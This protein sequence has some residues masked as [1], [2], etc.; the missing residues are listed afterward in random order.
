MKL[1]AML[2]RQAASFGMCSLFRS[3]GIVDD[4]TKILVLA[5]GYTDE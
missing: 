1:E 4:S 2:E 5:E 3:Q